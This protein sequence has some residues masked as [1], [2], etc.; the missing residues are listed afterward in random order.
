MTTLATT[1]A[2]WIRVS[3]HEQHAENQLPDLQAWAAR[4]GWEV[5]KVYEAQESAWQGAHLKLLSQVT[6][7]A[8]KGEFTVL[9]VWAL[10]RLSRGGAR[11][12]LEILNRLEQVG[13]HVYSYQEAWTE[14]AGPM[15]ELLVAIVGWVA[16]QESERRSE[17]TKAGLARAKA[18]GKVIG[19]PVGSKDLKG[20]RR[21]GYFARYKDR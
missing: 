1:V 18:N 6:R 15:R 11:A 20:R 9:L 21:S 8:R 4:R 7:D 16:Q 14:A 19:R 10:D 12:T 17:R 13:C 3:T 5:V 2:L